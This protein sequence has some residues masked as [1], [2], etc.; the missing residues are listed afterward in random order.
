MEK[1]ED[2]EVNNHRCPRL[3]QF[4]VMGITIVRYKKGWEL[5]TGGLKRG[6]VISSC[7]FCGTKL[8][9]KS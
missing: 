8:M 5:N 4:D 9:G 6:F 1:E 3:Y 2:V 7:P